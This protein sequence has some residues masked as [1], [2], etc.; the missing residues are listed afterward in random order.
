MRPEKLTGDR[1]Y[2]E[3]SVVKGRVATICNET[4]EIIS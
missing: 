2:D 4:K 3:G 1:F